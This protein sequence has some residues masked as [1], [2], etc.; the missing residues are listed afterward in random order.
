MAYSKQRELILRALQGCTSH[1]TADEVHGMLREDNP[2]MSLATVYRNLNQLVQNGIARKVSMP[3]GAD[4]FDG[5][6]EE[7][8]HLICEECGA[9]V[10]L[11]AECAP[12]P[13]KAAVE[14]SGCKINSHSILYYGFCKE[15]N[16]TI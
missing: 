7:H 5:I 16:D 6:Q 1:P 10:N 9:V 8:V 12:S 3:G 4:R 13:N 15:C 2:N 14:K 11:P